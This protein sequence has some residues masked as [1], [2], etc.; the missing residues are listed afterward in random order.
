MLL[1]SIGPLV[2]ALIISIIVRFPMP[3]ANNYPYEPL[4][5]VHASYIVGDIEVL[6]NGN[7]AVEFI[8]KFKNTS[9][10]QI[11][12]DVEEIELVVNQRKSSQVIYNSLASNTW[13]VFP[14]E[15]GYSDHDLYVYFDEKL[16]EDLGFTSYVVINH[17]LKIQQ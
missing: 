15:Q 9:K 10:D 13:P 3:S 16:D 4:P 14:L 5:N 8:F 11:I 17:G 12:F 2:L 7:S 1:F 6:E